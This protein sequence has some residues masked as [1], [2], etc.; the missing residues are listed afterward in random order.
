MRRYA[1]ALTV[2]LATFALLAAPL[3]ATPACAAPVRV[4]CA[5]ECC[6][7]QGSGCCAP[8]ASSASVCTCLAGEAPEQTPLPDRQAPTERVSVPQ[9]T[10][11][12]SPSAAVQVAEAVQFPPV[13]APSYQLP[14]SRAPP[15]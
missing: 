2:A 5:A 8:K 6:S 4:P 11:A 12:G 10:V 7:A 13:G 1:S 9:H 3:G 14:P 15:A